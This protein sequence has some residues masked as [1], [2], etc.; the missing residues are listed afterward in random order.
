MANVAAGERISGSTVSNLTRVVSEQGIEAL[1]R[2]N[3]ANIYRNLVQITLRVTL[4]DRIKHAYMPN[5]ISRYTGID[6]YW[7]I[8]ASAAMTM[9]ITA[10]ITYPFDLIH[11]RL[12]ADMSKKD[13][14]RLYKTTFDC[15]NRTNIDEGFRNGLY[16]GLELSV[17][18]SAM[19]TMLTLPLLDIVRAN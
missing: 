13:Q 10:A 12:A 1:W 14:T 17:L 9:G 3:M 7:R 16:K 2:G 11:T 4:Y 18:S 8:F 5:D 15:F 6:F 19:R